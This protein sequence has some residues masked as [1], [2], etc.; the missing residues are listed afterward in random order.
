MQWKILSKLDKYYYPHYIKVRG[1]QGTKV[2]CQGMSV[3]EITILALLAPMKT[4]RQRLSEA[5]KIP[6]Y[7]N[8]FS[9]SK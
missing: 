9:H 3:F 6:I 2:T 5:K 1:M 8:H 7:L 4:V